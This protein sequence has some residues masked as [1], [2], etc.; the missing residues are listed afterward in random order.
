MNTM[1][2]TPTHRPSSLFGYEKILKDR[3]TRV[4][5]ENAARERLSR[6]HYSLQKSRSVLLSKKR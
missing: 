6:K 2:N 1:V 4:S 3:N 5:E